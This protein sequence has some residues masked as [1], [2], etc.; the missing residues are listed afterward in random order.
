MGDGIPQS[1]CFASQGELPFLGIYR[2]QRRKPQAKFSSP[3][4]AWGLEERVDLFTLCHSSLWR[5]EGKLQVWSASEATHPTECV[6]STVLLN[7][8]LG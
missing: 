2:D 6:C 4:G 8:L 5:R 3:T 1:N 7:Q